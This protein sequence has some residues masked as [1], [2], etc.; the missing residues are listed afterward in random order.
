MAFTKKEI[1]RRKA[2][3]LKTIGGLINKGTPYNVRKVSLDTLQ[4]GDNTPEM[5]RRM[6]EASYGYSKPKQRKKAGSR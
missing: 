3:S 6:E 4:I 2:K 1:I 5:Y